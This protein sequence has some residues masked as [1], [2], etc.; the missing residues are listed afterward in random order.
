MAHRLFDI[1]RT[2]FASRPD[3]P[4]ASWGDHGASGWYARD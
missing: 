4:P 2:L 1:L 3:R